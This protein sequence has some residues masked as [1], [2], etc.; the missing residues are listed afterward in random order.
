MIQWDDQARTAK[1][2]VQDLLDTRGGP[3]GGLGSLAA[4][5]QAR[6]R[7]GQLV[8]RSWQA[9]RQEEEPDYQREVT[10]RQVMA[11]RDWTCV[12]SGR[13]DGVSRE[14]GLLVVEEVKSTMLDAAQLDVLRRDQLEGWCQQ[15]QLYMHFLAA[16]GEDVVGRLVL[17]SLVDGWRQVVHVPTDPGLREWLLAQL[18]HMV[19]ARE[20]LLAH[21]RH[22]RSA[23]LPFAHPLRRPGQEDIV[24]ACQRSLERG[25]H[26]LLSAPTGVGKTAA[27]L[28]G[29]LRA[30]YAADRRVFYATA[31]TTQQALVLDTLEAMRERGLV[32]RAL[33]LRAKGRGC[34]A[35]VQ[36]CHPE[37]C[38]YAADLAETFVEPPA[39]PLIRGD[40]LAAALGLDP[41]PRI[42]ELLERI[43]EEQAVGTVADEDAAV[44]FART[45]LTEPSA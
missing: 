23:P 22:R 10:I 24:R 6:A 36:D 37:R 30:A 14:G 25:R 39:P 31:R 40:R 26:L 38:P 13:I 16:G 17:I 4:S 41:G 1:L 34:L 20:D 43:A 44:A 12:I 21:R 33:G 45:L 15:L 5:P 8:H 29:A 2:G 3:D 27:V 42:G 35:E 9:E 28:Q 7:L 18:D 11:V 19:A 32:V